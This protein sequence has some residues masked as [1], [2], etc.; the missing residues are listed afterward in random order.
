MLVPTSTIGRKITMALTGQ[1]LVIF[2]IFHI[3]GNSTIFFHALNAYVVALYGLPVFVWG[4]RALL[5][6]AFV[7]HIWYGTVLKLENYAAKSQPYA[8]THYLKA[9]FAG[10]YQIWTGVIIAVFLIYHLLQF[11]FQVTNPS[12]A[13]DIHQ[14][15]L[16]R[17][18]VFTM[19][20]RSFQ[21]TAIAGVY[22]I[23]LAALGLHLLHGI[24]SSFQ[25]WGLTN[26]K[27]LPLIEKYG[28]IA[29]VILFLWYIAIPVVIVAG[30][31]K[32]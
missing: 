30:I 1:V 15:V 31:L 25:T 9:T 21:Q 14:D 8:V 16:G 4:G 11:T 24:Q 17:P 22:V 10:R 18:D 19:V 20:L 32:G 12:L 6:A 7:F 28:A 29:S 2:I 5:V 3:A 27:T 23:S 13:A 26:D